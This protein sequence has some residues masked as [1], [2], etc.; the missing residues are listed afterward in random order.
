MRQSV[1]EVMELV[2]QVQNLYPVSECRGK[3]PLQVPYTCLITAKVL[4]GG[5]LEQSEA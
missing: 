1:C 3:V 2:I 4:C 5:C